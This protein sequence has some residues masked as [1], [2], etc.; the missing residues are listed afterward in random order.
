MF[1]C[2]GRSW[3]PEMA[4]IERV[5]SELSEGQYRLL[6]PVSEAMGPADTE[7]R[8]RTAA[9]LAR[10]C[11]GGLVICYIVTFAPQT[12]LGSIERDDPA[13]VDAR[14]ATE[15]F[16]E[17]AAEIGV[18]ATGRIHPA[19]EVSGLVFGA[20]DAYDC[21]GTIL[22]IGG[23]RSQRRR[24]LAREMVESV[25]SRAECEVCVEKRAADETTIERILLAVSNGP[26]SG[27]AAQAARA[28]ALD[29]GASVDI[30][31]FTADDVDDD[32]R[33]EGMRILEAAEHVL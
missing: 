5:G 24:L 7:R 3:E 4:S 23:D 8:L 30:V 18:P 29:A 31:H 6:V 11:G 12:P 32:E 25:V 19:H 1:D 27:L 28:L 10:E 22:A 2:R 16:V 17:A 13:L 15:A 21:D 26:H 20:V 9:A 14:T 33:D